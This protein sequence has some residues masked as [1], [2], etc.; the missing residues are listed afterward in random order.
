M[1]GANDVQNMNWD[2]LD[3]GWGD[4]YPLL[5]PTPEAVESILK[6]TRRAPGDVVAIIETGMGVATVGKMAIVDRQR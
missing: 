2:Y 6:G 1:K 3:S 4:G 5:P